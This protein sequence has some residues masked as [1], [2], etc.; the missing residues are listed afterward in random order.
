MEAFAAEIG[1][2]LR[3][4]GD[5]RLIVCFEKQPPAP[6]R[7]FI[8][9]PGNVTLDVLP[10]QAGMG[11][12]SIRRFWRMLW[13][14]RPSVVLYS[15]GGAVRWWPMIAR[16]AGVR[17]IVYYDQTS[18][19]STQGYRARAHVRLLLAPLSKSVCATKFVKACSDR[20]GIVPPEK[21][22][23]LYSAVD[24]TRRHG[25]ALGFK[26]RYG[27][28]DDRLVVLQVSWLV[29]VKGIDVALRAAEKTISSRKDIHFVF[30]GDGAGREQYQQMA[31]DMGISDHVTWAG[32]LEDLPA[33]G[34]FSAANI[35]I[36]CSQW[37]E[38]FCLAVAE[39][40]H[41][42]LPIIASRIGGLPELVSDGVNGFLF[43]PHDH[44]ALAK[45]ILRLCSDSDLRIRM[46]QEGR[47]RAF[48]DYNLVD[49][50][51]TWID[52]LLGVP[53]HLREPQH[54]GPI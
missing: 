27:I 22:L 49:N 5:W 18:R 10:D 29:P 21:S 2:Q 43:D 1:R 16:L 32:Q 42:G 35:Q 20:E 12:N 19:L 25:A 31:L 4:R 46:G 17:R 14:H 44:A 47:E 13:K 24:C 30:C 45:L 36:Q 7:D 39:G 11:L 6:V 23:V 41:A 15:L 8:L 26:Q 28:P 38:A 37:H 50:V 34:A 9:R 52:L 53:T 3:A 40:M 48:R 51:N 33:S 54:S